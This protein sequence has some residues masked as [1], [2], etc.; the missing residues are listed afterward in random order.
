MNALL[1]IVPAVTL[2]VAVAGLARLIRETQEENQRQRQ[3]ATVNY[4]T[5]TIQRQHELYSAMHQDTSFAAK[6][7]VVA[8]AEFHQLTSYFG[9][10]EYLAAA[11]NM[12]IFDGEVVSRTIGSRIIRAYETFREWMETE[13]RRLNNNT[14]YEELDILVADLRERRDQRNAVQKPAE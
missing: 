7:S 4:I 2:L 10:L 1:A 6:A 5:S 3:R 14:V 9:Y 11:V 13:R 12:R 8:S